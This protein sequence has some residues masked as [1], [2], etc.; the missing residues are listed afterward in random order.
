M[1]AHTRYAEHRIERLVTG[2]IEM[3]QTQLYRLYFMKGVRL[4]MR[5][6]N[7]RPA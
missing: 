5:S 7:I 3:N 6:Y 4:P 1:A 2:L